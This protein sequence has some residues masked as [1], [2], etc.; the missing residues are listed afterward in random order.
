MLR[1]RLRRVGAKHK[2][3]YRIVVS[4]SGRTPGGRFNAVLG[5]Y[6]PG[7]DPAVIKVDVEQA[8]EWVRKGARPSET[9]AQL[10]ER[11]R[12]AP[13]PMPATV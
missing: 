11:A 10:I 3:Y 6:D 7:K 9:V 8:D 12:Q 4:E 13:A 1:I 2:P 5:T